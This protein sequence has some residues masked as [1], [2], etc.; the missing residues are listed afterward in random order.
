[1]VVLGRVVLVVLALG[2]WQGMDSEALTLPDQ[3]VAG[4]EFYYFSFETEASLPAEIDGQPTTYRVIPRDVADMPAWLSFSR[5]ARVLYGQVPTTLEATETLGLKI[6]GVNEGGTVLE[7]DLNI[8]TNPKQPG[9]PTSIFTLACMSA[10]RHGCLW[11]FQLYLLYYDMMRHER[12][13]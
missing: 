6:V 5:Q 8:E 11:A 9:R 1:M 7:A 3:S 10:R 2:S 12:S 4:G 13:V